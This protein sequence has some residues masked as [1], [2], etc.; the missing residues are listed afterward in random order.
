V[1]VILRELIAWA[2]ELLAGTLGVNGLAI[3]AVATASVALYYLREV[4]G[5]F[6]AVARW[7]RMVSILGFGLLIALIAAT[8][9]GLNLSDPSAIV[10]QLT[11][12]LH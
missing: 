3:G 12:V 8:A 2:L 1:A 4:S 5:A 10:A 7:A 11:E 6:V 9:L